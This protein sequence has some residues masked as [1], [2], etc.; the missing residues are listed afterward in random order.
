MFVR[1]Y[2]LF[3]LIFSVFAFNGNAASS[4]S[5]YSETESADGSAV[6][7]T[8][9]LPSLGSIEEEE[10]SFLSYFISGYDYHSLFLSNLQITA[11]DLEYYI[12][13]GLYTNL[14]ELD[15][16]RNGISDE[17]AKIIGDILGTLKFLKNLNLSSNRIG[18]KG[19]KKLAK[20]LGLSN[21]V[22]LNISHNNIK[23]M[24][25]WSIGK[26]LS[27]NKTLLSLG[28]ADNKISD[29]GAHFL[30]ESLKSN[31]TLEELTLGNNSIRS[32]GA[33]FLAEMLNNNGSLKKLTLSRNPLG[34]K[35][36]SALAKSL[37]NNNS[38]KILFLVGTE[39]SNCEDLSLALA[40]NTTLKELYLSHNHIE[41]DSH[42]LLRA[43]VLEI[44]DL[45]YNQI[46]KI[47]EFLPA[48]EKL[49]GLS[50]RGNKIGQEDIN[51]FISTL[52]REFKKIRIDKDE[53]KIEITIYNNNHITM[54]F[55]STP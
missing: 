11:K 16:S 44:L 40:Q 6:N 38:L 35:G 48:S 55:F 7:N 10:P 21:L 34:D 2:S 25:A 30:S 26:A 5:E 43:G 18:T 37:A 36:A 17:G 54:I 8:S 27:K 29:R 45:K 42:E 22:F 50:F 39:I 20:G 9:L 19:A 32:K 47:G 31:D 53:E 4:E 23:N 14:G 51:D 12:R 15:L 33:N 13:L 49:A 3:L 41:S 24:G 28:L 52:L 46:R 1:Q